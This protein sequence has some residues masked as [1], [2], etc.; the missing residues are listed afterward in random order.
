MPDLR[1]ADFCVHAVLHLHAPTLDIDD[2]LLEA[3]KI[4]RAKW[5]PVRGQGARVDIDDRDALYD[6]MHRG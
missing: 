5:T 4:H 6:V 2:A 1:V 3:A